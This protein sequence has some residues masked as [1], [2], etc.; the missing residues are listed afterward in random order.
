[1]TT[2]TSIVSWI[3]DK[4]D[5]DL[6]DKIISD[7][8]ASQYLIPKHKF[9]KGVT[10][11]VPSADQVKEL[12][13][14]GDSFVEN[15]KKFV[16]PFCICD[17]GSLQSLFPGEK[18]KIIPVLTIKYPV[19]VEV[20]FSSDLKIDG[21]KCVCDPAFKPSKSHDGAGT[22]SIAVLKPE[23]SYDP[24]LVSVEKVDYAALEYKVVGAG[25]KRGGGGIDRVMLASQIMNRWIVQM[26]EDGCI[27][28][29]PFLQASVSILDAI[30]DKD[31]ALYKKVQ[32]RIDLCPL[33]TFFLL[34][35]SGCSGEPFVA[36]EFIAAAEH[37]I[38]KHGKD[39]FLK[40]FPDTDSKYEGE[41]DDIRCQIVSIS[42][43]FGQIKKAY[44]DVHKDDAERYLWQDEMRFVLYEKLR[45]LINLQPEIMKTH[46]VIFD[47]LVAA[48]KLYSRPVKS[49]IIIK[50]S[51]DKPCG[52]ILYQFISSTDFLYTAQK[53]STEDP[54]DETFLN[55]NY[56]KSKDLEIFAMQASIFDETYA[57]VVAKYNEQRG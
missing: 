40:H 57:R 52:K 23:A 6:A 47:E 25:E 44:A 56:K 50:E 9:N 1:M 54:A 39:A 37:K 53:I 31:G 55:N 30:Q 4:L 42:S 29:N 8:F 45:P 51:L 7:Q 5:A 24:K 36:D 15:F 46:H 20:E 49:L 2:Y 12:K 27:S 21:V 11:I 48:I 33:I 10:F 32:E 18:K 35:E 28:S 22:R 34:V 38:I 3:K 16:L 13:K 19:G 43:A 17:K 14:D 41:V 26:A